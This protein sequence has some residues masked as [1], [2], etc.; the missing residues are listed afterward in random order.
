MKKNLILMMLLLAGAVSASAQTPEK[1]TGA[2]MVV[3]GKMVNKGAIVSKLPIDLR[4]KPEE[5]STIDNQEDGYIQ[6]PFLYVD[7]NTLFNN[8]GEA[9]IG[10]GLPTPK[11]CDGA[12]I[13][14]AAWNYVSGSLPGD[15]AKVGG[16]DATTNQSWS[17][18]ITATGAW[19]ATALDSYFTKANVDLCV[20][21]TNY[22]SSGVQ[23]G[24]TTWADAVNNC[25]NGNYADGDATVGWYLPNERELQ[26]IYQAIGG[27]GSAAVSFG[28][29]STG[30]GIIATTAEN[31]AL[32]FYWSSTEYDD[33][34]PLT[35]FFEKGNRSVTSKTNND[36][37]RC[38]RRL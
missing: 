32:G 21:K 28:N 27:N 3:T 25:A 24:T 20:Y 8:D 22:K 9:C 29:L 26:S 1:P 14:D 2:T 15:G 38:V 37:V 16:A 23:N 31:M 36:Y 34:S 13:Y 18:E 33:N 6:T 12:I 4:T 7:A 19:N 30:S 17:P 11:P 35:F 5:I 10:C